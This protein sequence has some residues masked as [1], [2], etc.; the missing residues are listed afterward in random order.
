[1]APGHLW[2]VLVQAWEG[3]VQFK[4]EQTANEYLVWLI[5]DKSFL[6]ISSH[7]PAGSATTSGHGC[8]RTWKLDFSKVYPFRT[9]LPR[10]ADL[11]ELRNFSFFGKRC[12]IL[13]HRSFGER[14]MEQ[15]KD[16]YHEVKFS[17][18]NRKLWAIAN[19]YC[20]L[21]LLHSIAR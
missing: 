21:I 8:K 17:L 2:L 9:V 20:S 16:S 6:C 11:L 10:N 18:Y 14:K 19:C 1:M 12:V 7:W 13:D 3:F 5:M 15:N 4:K